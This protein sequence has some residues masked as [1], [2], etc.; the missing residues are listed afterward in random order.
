MFCIIQFSKDLSRDSK[1][2]AKLCLDRTTVLYYKLRYG[3]VQTMN[4][5]TIDS[6]TNLFSL[7]FNKRNFDTNN[8]IKNNKEVSDILANYC[9]KVSVCGVYNFFLIKL[10]LITDFL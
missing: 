3:L 2:L 7:N 6:F 8:K 4:E 1:A 5:E 9:S 10:I